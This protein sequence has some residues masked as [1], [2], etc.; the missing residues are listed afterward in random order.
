MTTVMTTVMTVMTVMTSDDGDDDA[1]PVAPSISLSI[2][3][4]NVAISWP[5]VDGAT[6]YTIFYA[7]NPYLGPQ[8]VA[9]ADLGN[10]TSVSYDLWAGA[11]YRVAVQAYNDHGNSDFSNIEDF[12]IETPVVVPDPVD[13]SQ[14][15]AANCASCHGALNV[16]NV[17][18][19]DAE[20]IE[21]AIEENE[22][23]MGFLSFLTQAELN[24]VADVL[25]SH[26]PSASVRTGQV[27]YD[28]NCAGCHLVNG[29]DASGNI[30][31]ASKGSA[32]SSKLASGHG[33]R[34]K[35]DEI[36]NVSNWLDTWT[37]VPPTAV[38][39]TGQ[40]V[41]NDNCAGC[42]LVN[43]Y[44]ASGNIDLASKGSAASSKLASGHGGSVSGDEI[45]NVSNWLDTW[46]PV[47][48]PAVARTGQ[49]VYNDNCA[50]CHLVNGYDAS[51][52]ID[53]ASKGSAASSKLASGHGG[54]VSSDEIV[55]VSNW[56]DTF[57]PS[58]PG[59]GSCTSCHGQPPTGNSVPNRDGA[60]VVHAALNGLGGN[61]ASCHSSRASHNGNV[62]FGLSSSWNAKSGSAVANSNGTCSAVSCHGG[63]TTPNWLRGSINVDSQCTS[64]HSSGTAQYNG[65]FSGE[66]REHVNGERISCT[67]CHDVN[68]LRNGHFSNLA[69]RA[70]EQDPET[71]IKS[72]LSYVDGRCSTASCH[73]SER[74]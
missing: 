74:W 48:P 15:Y 7:P 65:Y 6:G 24:A 54:S 70:F 34:V 56:L 66:H 67:T 37:P 40:V 23:G 25:A 42:H 43:G 5:A 16:S 73:G 64:C 55:N 47:P 69:T 10:K 39:R 60:H 9:S 45:V 11:S 31:L 26:E 4:L 2:T 62:D 32:A 13:G 51:G 22:G 41:Y 68:V 46:A 58:Q 8:S 35:A 20:E 50:G 63:A 53:L 21:E 19:E 33:G 44:D 36:V 72:S 38:A 18:G 61:C 14:L 28:D 30:D 29:Y 49:A 27:V 17:G 59:P 3:G 71:T 57:S 12:V 1:A 52:N